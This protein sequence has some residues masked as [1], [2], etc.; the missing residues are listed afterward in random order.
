MT[1]QTT[2]KKPLGPT[3]ALTAVF[4]LS[5]PALLEPR[6]PDPSKPNE[7]VFGCEMLFRVAHT[8]ESQKRGEE[9]VSIEN[10]KAA[11]KA[12]IVE[13]WGADQ[14]RWPKGLKIPFKKG[15]EGK[16]AEKDGYGE[17]V[18][19]VRAT[20]KPE[21]GAPVLVDQL[22]APVVDKNAVYGGMYCRAKVHAYAWS[23]PRG[24]DG[25]SFTLDMI[26]LV[27]DGEPFGNRMS[28]ADAFDSL[29]MPTAKV[30]AGTAT[31]KVADSS[32][33]PAPT[34]AQAADVFG[35]L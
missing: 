12:A 27:K 10:L 1:T 33:T 8:P 4:R 3:D 17:G 7:K 15:T 30:P 11:A 22:V 19:Y 32:A 34:A 31:G 25:V 14:A 16:A 26:Q 28:A 23:H 5:Y 20:R 6:A 21:F 24:G 29:P 13:K 35:G 2:T 18:V 9:L